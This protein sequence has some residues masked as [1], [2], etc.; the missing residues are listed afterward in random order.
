M[1]EVELGDIVKD[2]VTGFKGVVVGVTN[3]LYGCARAI[4]QPEGVNKDGKTY[5]NQSFDVPQLEVV[6]KAKVIV[7]PIPK[8]EKTGGPR[9]TPAHK[10]TAAKE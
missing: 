5:D 2:K 4:V 9:M 8:N 3:W 6:K 7:A 10:Q 1:K